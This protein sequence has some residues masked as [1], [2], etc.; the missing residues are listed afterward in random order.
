MGECNL[1]KIEYADLHGPDYP[2]IGH[3]TH[4]QRR[5]ASIVENDWRT[6]IPCTGEN[7]NVIATGCNETKQTIEETMVKHKLVNR[8]LKYFE[9]LGK[10]EAN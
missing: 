4:F 8:L 5:T 3:A 7:G 10:I 2:E 1:D 9:I 6:E